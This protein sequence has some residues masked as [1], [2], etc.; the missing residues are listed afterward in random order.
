MLRRLDLDIKYLEN[1]SLWTDI[2]IIFLTSQSIIF[3]KK[4]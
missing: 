4:F 2:K 1:Y 3:G